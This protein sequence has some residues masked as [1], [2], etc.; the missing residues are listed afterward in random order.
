MS[1]EITILHED[2]VCKIYKGHITSIGGP[3]GCFINDEDDCIYMK[4]K[5]MTDRSGRTMNAMVYHPSDDTIWACKKRMP[6]SAV[7]MFLIAI[8]I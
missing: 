2:D 6:R 8:P 3:L 5:G 4:I 7:N 1:K